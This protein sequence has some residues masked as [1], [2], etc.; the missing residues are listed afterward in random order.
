M[1]EV[2]LKYNP[3]K[4]ETELLINGEPVAE[5]SLLYHGVHRMQ[6]WIDDFP[7]DLVKEYRS[8]DFDITFHGTVLDYEDLESAVQMANQNGVVLEDGQPPVP[9]HIAI[10]K[11]IPAK[12]VADKA[13]QIQELSEDFKNGPYDELRQ[14]DV[15]EAFRLAHNNE[16]PIN[17]IATMSAGKST[18]INSMLGRTLMPASAEACTATITEIHD[19]D[20]PNFYAEAF[21]KDDATPRETYAQLTLPIMKQLNNDP[22][23]S[24]VVIRGEIPFISNNDAQLILVDTPGPNNARDKAHH[25]ATMT[26]LSESSNTLVLYVMNA[27]SLGINDDDIFLSEVAKSMSGAGRLSRERF[28]FV[29]N[30]LDTFKTGEDSV[31]N[32]IQRVREYLESKGIK[33]PNIFPASALS[34]LNI[35]TLLKDVDMTSVDLDEIDEDVYEAIGLCRKLNGNP[36]KHLDEYAPLTPSARA[37]INTRLQKAIAEKDT[38]TSALIH[39]GVPS[40][41]EAIKT[42]VE[43]YS[44][45]AKITGIYNTFKDKLKSQNMRERMMEKIASGEA[46]NAK[47]Q[48]QIDALN[49]NI[50]DGKAA[51]LFKSNI[52]A[53]NYD[54]KIENIARGIISQAIKNATTTMDKSISSEKLTQDEAKSKAEILQGKMDLIIAQAHVSLQNSVYN[55]LSEAA[56]DLVNQYVQKLKSL[57]DE[58]GNVGGIKLDAFALMQGNIKELL[59][60]SQSLRDATKTEEVWEVVGNHRDYHELIGFR[61]FL[62]NHLGTNFNVDY[63]I[64]DDYDWVKKTYIDYR[65]FTQKFLAPIEKE[66]QS[67]SAACVKYAKEQVTAIKVAFSK[68]FDKLDSILK[69]K[70]SELDVS[71]KSQSEL[72]EMLDTCRKNQAW[73][74]EIDRKV[75]AILDI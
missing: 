19:A 58:Y 3:Y 61:R 9:V 10:S 33:E 14:P 2:F 52:N 26:A 28:I 41:E 11:Y 57:T 16:C 30:K 71:N 21:G 44:K 70:A 35:R 48:A 23:I 7:R 47:L 59:N 55:S 34:A 12:E 56:K 27:G 31:E 13:S 15:M 8:Q 17:V 6:E 38:K 66:L 73:L 67:Y 49:A 24:R 32:S 63:D 54:E 42:Y 37:A 25:E 39:S 51:D 60:Y 46:D 68:E 45:T 74:E 36:E 22:E 75:S 4:V 43:K 69:A 65:T 50:A 18:L 1:N 20:D 5:S 64:V 62:N 72:K 40:I 29:V 53:L